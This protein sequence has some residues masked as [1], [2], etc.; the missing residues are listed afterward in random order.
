MFRKKFRREY[1]NINY[2]NIF[3]VLFHSPNILIEL[4]KRSQNK[5]K[6]KYILDAVNYYR[7]KYVMSDILHLYEYIYLKN[8]SYLQIS[9]TTILPTWTIIFLTFAGRSTKS[10]FNLLVP[11]KANAQYK[12]KSFFYLTFN[13]S[14]VTFK[15][16]ESLKAW[17][18]C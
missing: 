14:C 17:M 16:L 8:S 2:F 13:Y 12:T 3:A 11:T 4:P 6:L 18:Q 1:T 5:M 10:I 7:F 9:L 15:S